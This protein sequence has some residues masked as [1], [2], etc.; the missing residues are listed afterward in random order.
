MFDLSLLTKE[1]LSEYLEI[2]RKWAE[3]LFSSTKLIDKKTFEARELKA[4]DEALDK[5]L[6]N[7]FKY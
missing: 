6:S 3:E 5:V 1:E 7:R 4:S 2:L